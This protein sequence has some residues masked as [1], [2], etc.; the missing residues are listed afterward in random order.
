MREGSSESQ[1]STSASVFLRLGQLWLPNIVGATT[2]WH[3][4]SSFRGIAQRF[5]LDKTSKLS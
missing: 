1:M 2:L 3:Q 5:A 4:H